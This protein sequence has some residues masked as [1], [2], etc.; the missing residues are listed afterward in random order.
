MRWGNFFKRKIRHDVT[1]IFDLGSSTVNGALVEIRPKEKPLIRYATREPLALHEK[2]SSEYL[3]RSMISGLMAVSLRIQEEGIREFASTH[4]EILRVKKILVIVGSP[5]YISENHFGVLEKQRPF[6]ITKDIIASIT[7]EEQKRFAKIY[8]ATPEGTTLFEQATFEIELNEYPIKNPYGYHA[9]KVGV[10]LF[11]SVM[12]ET[13]R[14]KTLET[15]QFIAPHA[16]IT[17]HT[18]GLAL[19]SVLRDLFH[20]DHS[21]IIA[22]ITGEVTDLFIVYED[23]LRGVGSFPLGTHALIR[24]IQKS[25]KIGMD[26]ARTRLEMARA[27][28][29]EKGERAIVEELIHKGVVMWQKECTANLKT[30]VPDIPLPR[31]IF[32]SVDSRYAEWF[33]KSLEATPL[34]RAAFSDRGFLPRVLSNSSLKSF[35]EMERVS[36]THPLIPLNALFLQKLQSGAY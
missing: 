14:T 22:D 28:V 8:G 10:G 25:S 17:F 11:E 15:I 23:K 12:S 29:L 1:A 19:F 31:T 20:N 4:K 13:V 18:R 2:A 16:E 9:R 26:E 6:K 32:L 24:G 21:Y 33:K 34:P 36:T 30:L 35:C 7:K 3:V 5:W 27:N